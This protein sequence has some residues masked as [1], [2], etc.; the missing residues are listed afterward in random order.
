MSLTRMTSIICMQQMVTT[1][2]LIDRTN[3]LHFKQGP[4]TSFIGWTQLRPEVGGMQGLHGSAKPRI[5]SKAS[6]Q[7]IAHN[8][9]KQDKKQRRRPGLSKDHYHFYK[10]TGQS[11]SGTKAASLVDVVIPLSN[12]KEEIYAALDEWVAFEVEF[13]IIAVGKALKRLKEQEQWQ[14][15]IQVSKWM[16]SKGQGKTFGTYDLML[17]AY[18]MDARLEDCETLWDKLLMLYARSMPKS[19]FARMMN[20][21]KRQHMPEKLVKVF[22]QMEDFKMR[23]DKDTLEMVK[24]AYRQLGQP[25]KQQALMAK[26]PPAWNYLTFKG[27]TIKVR[28]RPGI[29]DSIADS[30]AGQPCEEPL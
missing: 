16:L 11:G 21:Y 4:S 18:E 24:E 14:R 9:S 19:M 10:R 26:Y 12:V 8:P 22:E 17:K 7:A 30:E 29:K 27:K 15:I 1:S 13:P 23:P 20:I 6:I 25:E 5:L 3:T 2:E 28:P